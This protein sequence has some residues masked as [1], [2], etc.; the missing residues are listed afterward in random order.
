MTA[1]YAKPYYPVFLDLAGR[2]CVI[3]GGGAVALRKARTLAEYKA[4]VVVIA[5]DVSAELVEMQAD[6][7]ITVEQRGYVRGDLADAFLAICATDSEEVNRAVYAE[8]QERR[9]LVNVVDVPELC[10][11]IGP[12]VVRRGGLQIA[13]STGGAAPAVAKR[14]RK[15][16]SS[17]LGEEWGDYVTLMGEVR[18]LVIERVPGG[19]AA[20]KPIFERIAD[21]DLLER[22]GRGERP[23]AKKVFKEFAAEAAAEAGAASAGGTAATAKKARRR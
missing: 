5:P 20:R 1:D 22:M 14:L 17:E 11:F 10:S 3:V 21:S 23:S 2:L 7:L 16:F 8:A 4:D 9:C 12:S 15:R 19:E 18:A 6:G 13:I